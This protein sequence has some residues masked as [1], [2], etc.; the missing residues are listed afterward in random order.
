MMDENFRNAIWAAAFAR[1][2]VAVNCAGR[3][4]DE[5]LRLAILQGLVAEA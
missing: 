3:E 1:R 5:V 4:A 2:G